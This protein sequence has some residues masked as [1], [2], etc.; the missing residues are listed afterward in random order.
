[1]TVV[2]VVECAEQADVL[3]Q[4]VTPNSGA[5]SAI[6]GEAV[7]AVEPLL[8]IFM[9]SDGDE[10]DSSNDG[11]FYTAPPASN[12]EESKH[13]YCFFIPKTIYF[14]E[15]SS[16]AFYIHAAAIPVTMVSDI[17]A[18]GW[19][20]PRNS[21][22]RKRCDAIRERLAQQ[23]PL[24]CK[25]WIPKRYRMHSI[26]VPKAYIKTIIPCEVT[27]S[28][29]KHGVLLTVLPENTI[30]EVHKVCTWAESTLY[31]NENV[32]IRLKLLSKYLYVGVNNQQTSF[33]A[34]I[35]NAAGTD[36]VHDVNFGSDGWITYEIANSVKQCQFIDVET[37][38]SLSAL[39]PRSLHGFNIERQ[40]SVFPKDKTSLE[41][42]NFEAYKA[43][44]GNDSSVWGKPR[45]PRY[46]YFHI[47]AG[48]LTVFDNSGARSVGQQPLKSRRIELQNCKVFVRKP[49]DFSCLPSN[50][51]FL[52]NLTIDYLTYVL[53]NFNDFTKRQSQSTS[54]TLKTD[55]A[56]ISGTVK[57]FFTSK[58]KNLKS[59]LSNTIQSFSS[60]GYHSTSSDQVAR[61]QAE[62]IT[63]EFDDFWDVIYIA[64]DF[65]HDSNGKEVQDR[66]CKSNLVLF[67]NGDIATSIANIMG[68]QGALLEK[69]TLWGDL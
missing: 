6:A 21:V 50:T 24:E 33:S 60:E 51:P 59:D 39:D 14:L 4:L 37:D 40:F 58:L 1:M 7:S 25:D 29:A 28:I 31:P 8:Y 23:R 56:E 26:D 36:R 46:R 10:A 19:K 42:Y 34:I 55:L 53:S 61:A 62:N 45:Y 13:D 11:V 22:A 48:V 47:Y 16:N 43:A 9:T 41:S 32:K 66:K 2:R 52:T 17:K 38:D 69:A 64:W 5:I 30:V 44:V 35:V 65:E 3:L 15:C 18:A 12:R 63:Q 27:S 68:H 54:E 49:S 57:S 20:V 67:V